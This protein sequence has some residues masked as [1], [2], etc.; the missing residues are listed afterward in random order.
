M[1]GLGSLSVYRLHQN[2][3]QLR[4]L[5]RKWGDL[6]WPSYG[7]ILEH[8]PARGNDNDEALVDRSPAQFCHRGW[9]LGQRQQR[10][11]AR[12][13]GRATRGG[14]RARTTER[15]TARAGTRD[16]GP[17]ATTHA[18]TCAASAPQLGVVERFVSTRFGDRAASGSP[19]RSGCASR[20][21]ASDVPR[22][23]G[24]GRHCARARIGDCGL[25]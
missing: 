17:C 13:R 12:T 24:S 8:S 23:D 9:L 7:P 4:T 21:S 5:S 10:A 6:T 22:G 14:T 1:L 19:I 2:R 25:F 18:C 11:T 15:S 20:A 16:S 3:S